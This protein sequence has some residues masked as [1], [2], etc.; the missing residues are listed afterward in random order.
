[1]HF[2]R[3]PLIVGDITEQ[4]FD[5]LR[6]AAPEAAEQLRILFRNRKIVVRLT[7]NPAGGP[8]AIYSCA[9]IPTQFFQRMWV[10]SYGAW[11]AMRDY[12]L[13]LYAAHLSKT[14]I[15]PGAVER[16]LEQMQIHAR[17]LEA[18]QYASTIQI[19]EDQWPRWV[20]DFLSSASDLQQYAINELFAMA[21]AWILLHEVQHAAFYDDPAEE[22]KLCDSFATQGLLDNVARY[23]SAT[24]EPADL[25]VGK[26]AMGIFVALYVIGNLGRNDSD[27]HPP[28][29]ERIGALFSHVGTAPAGKFWHYVVG[30][31]YAL[32]PNRSELHLGAALDL[33]T[34]ALDLASHL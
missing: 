24:K 30:L 9:E 6:L 25:V 21:V 14:E 5:L 26:R 28:V 23:A 19:H 20:P 13:V 4:A 29:S 17:S 8:Q 15:H 33:R 32:V 12:G 31:T 3:K 22:E 16:T 1:M 27:S 10:L 7:D 34:M 11:E 18:A 2:L